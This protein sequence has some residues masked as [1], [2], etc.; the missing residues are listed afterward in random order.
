MF[1]QC[2]WR[3]IQILKFKLDYVLYL[4]EIMLQFFFCQEK[5]FYIQLAQ[6]ILKQLRNFLLTYNDP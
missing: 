1:T 2:K 3:P 6:D 5:I 4:P